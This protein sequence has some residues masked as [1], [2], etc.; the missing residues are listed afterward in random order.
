MSI[1]RRLF[2]AFKRRMAGARVSEFRANIASPFALGSRTGGQSFTTYTMPGPG[3]LAIRS[4]ANQTAGRLTINTV[5]VPALTANAW[6]EL[7]WLDEGK[8]VVIAVVAGATAGTLSVAVLDDW[9]LPRIIAT[10][11]I[12]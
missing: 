10:G 11:T 1:A 5:A 2:N 3:R 7:Y 9:E 6:R 8:P 12:T 4:S